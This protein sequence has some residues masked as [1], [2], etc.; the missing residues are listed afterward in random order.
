MTKE[1]D[2][3]LPNKLTIARIIAVPIY[4]AAMLIAFK[5][6]TLIAGVIFILAS[7]T[8][9]LDGKIA[10]K[11]N[12]VSD[13]GKFADPIADKILV[14][15]SV[16]IFTGL[17][18]VSSWSCAIMV[19]REI[20]VTGLRNM[21]VLKGR[22]LAADIFG[23][24][25]TTLQMIALVLMHFEGLLPVVMLPATVIYYASVFFTVLSGANYFIK[26]RDV[27]AYEK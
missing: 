8:D 17:G 4:A 9:T 3:N 24:I 7:V 18:R 13:F 12:L 23:K 1:I 15:T 20:A 5:H 2:K 11:Y 27:I 21:A 22:V 16:I 25:K 14:L 19:A 26:N 10:R 6:H